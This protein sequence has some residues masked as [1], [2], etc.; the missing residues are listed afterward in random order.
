MI[1]TLQEVD[2]EGAYLNIIM[3]IYDKLT[4]NNLFNSEKLKAFP[5]TT[6]TKQGCLLLILLFNTVL[7]VLA[8][9]ILEEKERK[10]I[11]IGKEVKL[12]LF[13]DD[14]ILYIENPKGVTRKLPEL[15]AQQ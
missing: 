3:V 5:V 15:R 6:G 1:K 8:M 12:S 2:I 9:A 11:Q 10:G 4:A 13:A 7:E 14:L